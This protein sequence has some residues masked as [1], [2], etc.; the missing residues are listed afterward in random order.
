MTVPWWSDVRRRMAKGELITRGMSLNEEGLCSI[1]FCESGERWEVDT[2]Q[3]DHR[4]LRM[5]WTLNQLDENPKARHV[6]QIY[7]KDDAIDPLR[8]THR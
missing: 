8:L 3:Y 4:H 6:R 7:L 5:V 2:G 1:V